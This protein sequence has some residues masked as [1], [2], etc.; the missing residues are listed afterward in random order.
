MENVLILLLWLI[1]LAL[2]EQLAK[3]KKA[4]ESE[5]VVKEDKEDKIVKKEEVPPEK[6]LKEVKQEETLKQERK[7]ISSQASSKKVLSRGS[8][9]IHEVQKAV[10]YSEILLP[11]RSK[12]PFLFRIII[13]F[14]VLTNLGT[15]NLYASAEKKK[16]IKHGTVIKEIR[17]PGIVPEGIAFDG[18]YL[19][20]VDL[21]LEEDLMPTIYQ[22]S[23]ED[24][25]I[26]S[27][28]PAPG[29]FPEGLSFDGHYLWNIDLNTTSDA[30]EPLIYKIN[31]DLKRATVAFSAPELYPGSI[32]AGITWDGKYLWC[33]E[34]NTHNIFKI[35]SL[36]GRVI[37]KFKAPA[38]YPSGLVFKEG[39]L[40]MSSIL[41]QRIYK[42][43]PK[44]GEVIYS[45]C[46]PGTYPYGL[47]FEGE[48]LWSGDYLNNTLYKMIP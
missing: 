12:R 33:A 18:K 28:F 3:K 40:W 15:L 43:D 41:T 35:D 39:F 10:I 11:P 26:L 8:F 24:G 2:F 1:A 42:I 23:S 44:D 21:N 25:K 45:F 36:S 32:S 6:T 13:F 48:Y 5:K 22:I 14:I 30:G 20:V 27:F 9:K 37:Y 46:H 31:L 7:K 34:A 19:W 47:A 29:K 16:E 17:A 4:A 38:M